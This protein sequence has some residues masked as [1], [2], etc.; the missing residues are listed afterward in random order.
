MKDEEWNDV[1]NINL[2]SNFKLT[3]KILRTTANIINI[4]ARALTSTNPFIRQMGASKIH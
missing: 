3:K 1:I 2:N 4:G